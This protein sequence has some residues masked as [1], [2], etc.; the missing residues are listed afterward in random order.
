[1]FLALEQYKDIE[2][3]KKLQQCLNQQLI[4]GQSVLGLFNANRD[5]EFQG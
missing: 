1:M 4:F 2:M 5:Q 3:I